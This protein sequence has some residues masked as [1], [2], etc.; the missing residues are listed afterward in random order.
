MAAGKAKCGGTLKGR[1][2]FLLNTL[3]DSGG[4]EAGYPG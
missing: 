1:M 4:S 2:S 3:A